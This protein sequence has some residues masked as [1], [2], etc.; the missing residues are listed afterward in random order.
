MDCHQDLPKIAQSGHSGGFEQVDGH[1]LIINGAHWDNY[2]TL[3]LQLQYT[4]KDQPMSKVEMYLVLST[5]QGTF[6]I[7]GTWFILAR[8]CL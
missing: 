6:K 8:A 7:V 2:A 1:F 3:K 4:M 5:V